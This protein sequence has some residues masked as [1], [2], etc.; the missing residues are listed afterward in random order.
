MNNLILA[1]S[2]IYR[3]EILIKHY[4]NF[5]CISPDIDETPQDDEKPISLAKRLADTKAKKISKDF[6]DHYVIGSDQVA[7]FDERILGKPGNY[8]NALANFRSFKGKSVYF[9]AG[10]SI[11]NESLGV[12]R[13]GLETTEIRFRNYSDETMITYLN[14]LDTFSTTAG[15]KSESDQFPAL[16]EEIIADDECAIIGLP[17]KWIL[18]QLSELV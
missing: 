3:Q 12:A 16:V 4:P 10:V 18:D 1:S 6:P 7:S 2:S 15:V 8:K 17:I 13:T 5:R 14:S 11:R 9:H